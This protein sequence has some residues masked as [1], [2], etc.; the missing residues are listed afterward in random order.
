[1]KAALVDDG[2]GAFFFSAAGAGGA[3]FFPVAGVDGASTN[4]LDAAAASLVLDPGVGFGSRESV[5]AGSD[6]RESETT[7]SGGGGGSVAAASLEEGWGQQRNAANQQMMGLIRRG[8]RTEEGLH[9][10]T[11]MAASGDGVTTAGCPG[12]QWRRASRAAEQ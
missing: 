9:R 4:S 12:P 1:M 3:F 11:S 7:G 2:G 6:S 10:A 5:T 8:G